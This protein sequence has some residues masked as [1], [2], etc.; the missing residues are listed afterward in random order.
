MDKS[1]KRW[2]NGVESDLRVMRIRQWWG[3]AEDR[4]TWSEIVEET[5]K[6]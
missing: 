5:T 6:G 1:R 2:K 3:V 4:K